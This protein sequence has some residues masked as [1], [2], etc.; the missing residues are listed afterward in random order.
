MQQNKIEKVIFVFTCMV[1]ILQINSYSTWNAHA[2][3]LNIYIYTLK[4]LDKTFS[5]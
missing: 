5:W 4:Q 2:V 3:T 1:D